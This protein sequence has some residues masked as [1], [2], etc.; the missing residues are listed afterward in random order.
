MGVM[1]G[2]G[3]VGMVTVSALVAVND[4]MM[5]MLVLWLLA[6]EAEETID[7]Q[8]QENPHGVE[9][10]R[11]HE[12]IENGGPKLGERSLIVDD[13]IDVEAYGYHE[14]D[15][16]GKGFLTNAA[17]GEVEVRHGRVES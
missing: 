8:T 9:D 13:G 4:I 2:M 16:Q 12:H 5:A 17:G 10:N 6:D 11:G 1:R 14:T 7:E 15:E 3:R